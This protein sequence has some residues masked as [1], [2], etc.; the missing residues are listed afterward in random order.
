MAGTIPYLWQRLIT[1]T[2]QWPLH[3]GYQN[4]LVQHNTTP[5]AAIEA[6]HLSF[7]VNSAIVLYLTD[8]SY[9]CKD[10]LIVMWEL[11]C[12]QLLTEHQ[13]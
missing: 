10:L 6:T 5:A 9:Y 2:F 1:D 3:V 12:K 7:I 11:L 4:I 13:F 8:K